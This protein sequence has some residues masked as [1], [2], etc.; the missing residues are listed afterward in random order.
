MANAGVVEQ[1]LCHGIFIKLLQLLGQINECMAQ[2][3]LSSMD[4]HSSQTAFFE[5]NTTQLQMEMGLQWCGR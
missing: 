2:S 5:M 1:P 4:V 3:L